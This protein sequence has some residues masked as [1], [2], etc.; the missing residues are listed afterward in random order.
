MYR[1][2][3]RQSSQTAIAPLSDR[4]RHAG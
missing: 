4:L 1:R 3:N 2:Q